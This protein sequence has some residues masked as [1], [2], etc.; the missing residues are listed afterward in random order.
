[1]EKAEVLDDFSAS[2]FTGQVLKPHRPSRRRQ[3]RDWE[4]EERPTVGEDQVRDQLRNLKVHKSMGPDEMHPQVLREL[5]D[6]AAKPLSIISEKLWQSGEVPTDWKRGNIMEQILL[7]TMLMRMENKEVTGDSQHGFT[8]GKLCL[9]NLVA[10]YNGVTALVDKGRANGVIYLDL[11]KAFD[12]IPH[13]NLVSKLERHGFDRWTTRWI[14][15]RLDGRTQRVAVNGSIFVGDTDSGIECTLSKFANDTKLCGAVNTLEGRDAIQRDLD[16]LER[17]AP[18]RLMKFNKAKR[19]VLHTGRGNP[20][21]KYRLGGEWIESSPAEK[22]LGVLVDEKLNMTQQCALT[23]QKANPKSRTA[24][25]TNS[26]YAFLMAEPSNGLRLGFEGEG[27]V[28]LRIILF[29]MS[30]RQHFNAR[31]YGQ[32]RQHIPSRAVVLLWMEGLGELPLDTALLRPPRA[33]RPALEPSAQERHGAVG[34]GPEEGTETIRGLEHLCCGERLRELGVFS[35]EKRRLRGDLIVAFQY[36]KG[37]Y[38]KDGDR[39]FSRAGCDRTRGDGFKPKEGRFRLDLRK[40]CFTMRVVRPWPRLPREV[41]DAPSL[42]VF[43]M[44]LTGL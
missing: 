15:N 5:V 43:K 27:W 30:L 21:H 10:F 6:E 24:A 9:T 28:F 37:A 17:R 41:G 36:L 18:A 42:E 16:R 32:D 4:K 22:D 35:L 23:A 8:R 2:V 14:R 39:L 34:A 13:D 33:L 25:R 7:E 3:S 44:R 31:R 26:Q 1:M 19:K 38:R 29:V 20:K 12:T 11:C 40:K